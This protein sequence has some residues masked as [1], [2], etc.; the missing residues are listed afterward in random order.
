MEAD[1]IRSTVATG[2]LLASSLLAQA[3]G[4]PQVPVP[5][6]N[7]ITSSKAL[8]GKALFFEEQLSSTRNMAC[9]TCHVMERGSS[10]PRSLDPRS[11]HPGADAVFNTADDVRG[12]LG[13]IGNEGDGS[14][15]RVAGF[16]LRPQVT[17]RRAMPVINSAFARDLFWDGRVRGDFVDPQTQQVALTGP[18]QLESQALVP[19]ENTVEM[20]HFGQNWPDVIARLQSARPLALASDLPAALANFIGQHDYPELFRQV[21]GSSSITAARIAMVLATYQRTLISDQSPFDQFLRGNRNALTAQQL[22]GEQIFRAPPAACITCHGGPLATDNRFHYT[23]VSAPLADRGRELVTNNPADRGRMRTPS[24]RN[25]ALRA[26]FFHDGS[27]RTLAEVV[28]FYDRGGNFNAPNRAGAIRPLGLSR[29]TR[30]PWSPSCR[31]S[32]I[33]ASRRRRLPSTG[34][35]SGAKGRSGRKPTVSRRL[36]RAL[37]RRS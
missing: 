8:L 6:G 19:L 11:V 14:Y 32:P 27:A 30:R 20:A 16:D 1:M 13:V 3:P 4:F 25:V 36:R 10:D 29:R 35:G 12:S 2:F 26:P 21:F 5:A 37:P 23:G 31:P 7:P 34:P 18:A 24:L 28:D 33:R 17:D 15:R 22:R 9:A